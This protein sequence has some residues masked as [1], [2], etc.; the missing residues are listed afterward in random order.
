[1][2]RVPSEFHVRDDQTP[3][4]AWKRTSRGG[5][6]LDLPITPGRVG[7]VAPDPDVLDVVVRGVIREPSEDGTTLVSL[8]LVNNQ[9][10]QKD[11]Q[12][13]DRKWIFQP[14]LEV[15]AMDGEMAIFERR[16]RIADLDPDDPG[17]EEQERALLAMVCRKHAEFA[18]G[19]GVAVHAVPAGNPWT[20]D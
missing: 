2:D 10:V 5:E 13:K 19:H 17:L 18:V 16:D 3:R 9:T 6:P 20:A 8:F 1:Y 12:W 7:P 11:E 4:M 15:S 14:S